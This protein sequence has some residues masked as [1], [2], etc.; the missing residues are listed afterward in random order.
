[1]ARM[2][3]KAAAKALGVSPDVLESYLE[4]TGKLQEIRRGRRVFIPAEEVKALL[5][6]QKGSQDA[7]SPVQE[8][9]IPHPPDT[10]PPLKAPPLSMER[11]EA[12]LE[13]IGRLK[14]QTRLL[15]Q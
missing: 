5:R 3:V 6:E 1:M 4:R 9:T 10:P 2:T 15:E 13:E 12:L 7:I 14:Y 8:T 11:Y